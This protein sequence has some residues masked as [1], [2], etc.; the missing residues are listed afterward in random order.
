MTF[1]ND[2]LKRLKTTFT[3]PEYHEDISEDIAIWILNKQKAL[4]ARL[5]AAEKLSFARQQRIGCF[6]TSCDSNCKASSRRLEAI[7]LEVWR[8][9]KGEI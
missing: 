9:S 8:K 6:T 4:L 1:T 3:K 7:A 2:D 5:E